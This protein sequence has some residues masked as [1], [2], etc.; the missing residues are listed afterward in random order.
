MGFFGEGLYYVGDVDFF[1][2]AAHAEG[3]GHLVFDDE[4]S[5]LQ[6]SD[7]WSDFLEYEYLI[8]IFI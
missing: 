8:V 2:F 3:K 6:A 1:V 7:C 4:L 5:F